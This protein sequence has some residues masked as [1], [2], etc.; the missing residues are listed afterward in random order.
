MTFISCQARDNL[1]DTS[2]IIESTILWDA[3]LQSD[4]T[5]FEMSKLLSDTTKFEKKG[6]FYKVKSDLKVFG[7]KAIYL[8][9]L[10]IDLIPGPNATLEGAPESIYEYV[11]KHYKLKFK[12]AKD[13]SAYQAKIR[14]YL[15]LSI[16]KH[17]T[18]E[19]ATI[20]IG[21]YLG[22]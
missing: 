14:E 3:K 10:G 13:K 4:W 6:N 21:A 1:S 18:M 16:E 7:H 22:P 15:V 12:S 2:K 17:P 11:K 20:V 9:M 5:P 19:N 8:G